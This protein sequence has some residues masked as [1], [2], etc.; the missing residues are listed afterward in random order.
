MVES[1][2]Y[3]GLPRVSHPVLHD[4][5]L[6]ALERSAQ[7]VVDSFSAIPDAVF[8]EGDSD[9]WAPAHHVVHLTR[10][11]L[12]VGAAMRA[13]NLPPH[14]TG[15]SRT[16]AEVRDAAA[17]SLASASKDRLLEMGRTVTLPAGTGKGEIVEAFAVASAALRDAA[18][19]W[20]EEELDHHAMM[21]PML[22]SLT[23]REMLF[24]F[25]V[26]EQHHRKNVL[27]Q[28]AR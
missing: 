1:A 20:S 12:S 4:E 14:A 26:H 15:R 17:S 18:R 28:L 19:T 23:A 10:A 9:R 8:F 7:S 2:F 21:H 22:G 24:F 27:R 13:R 11:S 3:D 25:V 16:F 5:I 6:A